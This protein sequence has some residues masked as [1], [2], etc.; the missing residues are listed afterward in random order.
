MSIYRKSKELKQALYGFIAHASSI[1]KTRFNDILER[2]DEIEDE[3]YKLEEHAKRMPLS[4]T[5]ENGAKA[6]LIGEF[7]EKTEYTDY[8]SG[9]DLIFVSTVSW[10]TIKDIY[11]KI[12]EHYTK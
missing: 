10:T 1:D 9:D 7:K 8:E 11:K 12:V 4:L 2:V 6:L 3:A 5:A